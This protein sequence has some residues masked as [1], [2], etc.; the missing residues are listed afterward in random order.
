LILQKDISKEII[1]WDS[2]T[3]VLLLIFIGF[4]LLGLYIIYKQ[5]A[6]VKKGEFDIRDKLQ[7]II[8]GFIFSTSVMIVFGM[9]FIFAI[10]TPEFWINSSAP[11]PKLQPLHLLIPFLICLA[12]ISL[13]PLIDFLFI[14]LSK[15]SDEGLTPFHKFL[16]DRWINKSNSKPIRVMRAV[17]LYIIM[18]APPI[19]LWA[20]FRAPFIMVLL[21]SLLIYPLM[22]LTFYGSKGY[23]AGISNVYYHIPDLKRSIFLAFEDGK[24]SAEEFKAD[25]GPRILLGLMLFVFAWAWISLI[26]TFAFF[27]TGTMVVSTM[28]YTGMVFVTLLMG[29]I[30][31][32]TRFWG[33]KIKYRGIDIYFAAFLMAAVGINVLVNFMIVNPDKLQQ[34]FN[35]TLIG[36]HELIPNFRTFAFAAVI[37]EVVLIVF[38]TYYF[39]TKKNE[40]T[41]NI[42]YALITQSSQTFD[43]IPLFNF[44]KSDI[45]RVR[46][47]A[48]ESLILMFER[49]PFKSEIDI[50]QGKFK[51]SLM[52]GVCDPN[53]HASSTCYKILLQL[54]NDVPD[55]V[56]PWIIDA[57]ESPNY[58][59]SIPIANSL[60]KSDLKL[61]EEI[62]ESIIFN[63]IEDKEWRLKLL[64]LKIL[65]R[66]ID[67][68]N[69]LISNLNLDKLV[70]DPD[71]KVQVEILNILAKSSIVLPAE[72]IIELINNS[73][74]EIRAA[75][76]KNIK[77]LD[78]KRITPQIIS[79]IMPLMKDTNAKVRSSI[80][81]VFAKVGHFQKFFIPILP[82]LDGLTDLNEKVRTSSID[83]LEKYFD[84]QP[85]ALDIDVIISKI[86]PNNN[87]V[88]NSVLTLLGRLW[89][90]DP[91]KILMTFLIFIK[92]DNVQLKQNIS[93]IL[94]EK[95]ETNPELI[96]Q[97]LIKLEDMAGF[98]TKGIISST[99]IKIA[100]K[101]PNKI[102]PKLISYLESD[103]DDIRLNA[104]VSLEGLVDDFMEKLQLKPFLT[105]L[106][107][108]ENKKIKKEASKVISKIAQ[109]NPMAIK[110]VMAVILQSLYEQE[111]SV[112][113]VLSKSLL[114]IAKESP[115]IIP[116]RPVIGFLTDQE[117]FIRETGAKILGYIG[118]DKVA[119]EV[120][121]ALINKGILDEE[122]IV[123]E[124]A[125]SSLGNILE[126]ID[127]KRLII[128]KLVALLDDEKAWV[129]RSAIN[130]I[131]NIEGI[132]ASQIPFEKVENNLTSTD[133]K[134]RE[135]SAGLLKIYGYS[136]IDR[137]F[138]KILSLLEDE[139]EEVR[140]NMIKT[141]VDIIQQI[142]L[143]R[144]LSNLLMQLSDKGNMELQRSIAKIFAK[145]VQYEDD[146]VKKRV[147]ALLKIRCEMSQDPV[148]C[149]TLHKLR[150]G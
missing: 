139:E 105:L 53:P 140:K 73:N 66:L 54:E 97:N 57:L 115:E 85:G 14:A 35:F 111:S 50:N 69:E 123:R 114:D 102:I 11:A 34:T 4:F 3:I 72:I 80:F 89:E 116:I 39:I 10:E 55:K 77:N 21:T 26:Q 48:Q 112:K 71:S 70:K 95:Y 110:P 46:N 29:I 91:E 120:A 40:F 36:L 51:N 124:A 12:Y 83:A 130:I 147:V 33:R 28:S 78:V 52:D 64:G 106:Q 15:E 49:I 94:V 61:V 136:N 9:A 19:F 47:H 148:I 22:I 58:D 86:D 98:V 41:G 6:L 134:V 82:F 90:K 81:E 84:E 59:K 87:E 121:D 88:L 132:K 18:V 113:I 43:P 118:T 74:K 20:I 63:L 107:K 24:R 44:I 96:I 56:L 37:E 108:D 143:D 79:K 142:G 75:G 133:A 13:Y 128:P 104:V 25:P 45:P 38:T 7:C 68:K 62:P 16:G 103:N 5:V 65:S 144:V 27:F 117:S 100:Q 31:Y 126:H 8:Y 99:I 125:V 1:I 42:K 119:H 146:K 76:I 138:E 135:A 137:I 109:K 145:T 93:E 129:R 60:L 2:I 17:I 32:F 122:W 30:G 101:D 67:K 127:D 131:S 92:F 150:E 141:M 149:E 23:I